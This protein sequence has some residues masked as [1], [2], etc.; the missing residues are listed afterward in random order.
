MPED[1]WQMLKK[2]KKW[3]GDKKKILDGILCHIPLH[4]PFLTKYRS[5]AL[6]N[7]ENKSSIQFFI[8]CVKK[9]SQVVHNTPKELTSHFV[10]CRSWRK[11]WYFMPCMCY[12]EESIR[13][14]IEGL[15]FKLLFT[16]MGVMQLTPVKT[17]PCPAIK[18]EDFHFWI[19]HV[20]CILA[21]MSL[22][23]AKL[24]SMCQYLF[25]FQCSGP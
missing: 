18:D 20:Q 12:N 2:G 3:N 25:H 1:I 16:L 15:S 4:F 17:C 14:R 22:I 23:W 9:V 10:N 24:C 6:Q 7:W 19:F 11:M 21:P 13:S 5:E 8:A